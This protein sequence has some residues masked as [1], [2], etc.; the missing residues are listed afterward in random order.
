[1]QFEQFKGALIMHLRW[2]YK[3]AVER[4]SFLFMTLKFER[5]EIMKRIAID[6]ATMEAYLDELYPKYFTR[7]DGQT[8]W[9]KADFIRL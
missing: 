8:I 6:R 7:D 3:A 5:R 4:D 2:E 9:F 1:M